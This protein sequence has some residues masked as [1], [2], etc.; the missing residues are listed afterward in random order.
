MTL[1]WWI[2]A[3]RLNCE[4]LLFFDESARYGAFSAER[5]ASN[6]AFERRQALNS[7]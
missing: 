6:R 2:I 3:G 1:I 5:G 4:E 7:I